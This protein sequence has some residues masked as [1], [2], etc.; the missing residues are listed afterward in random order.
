[1]ACGPPSRG[2]RAVVAEPRPPVRRVGPG[3]L[4]LRLDPQERRILAS[5]VAELRGELEDPESAEPAGA[6]ARLYPPAF[7]DDPDAEAAYADLVLADLVET[8]RDRAAVMAATIDAVELDDA[9]AAAWL[10]TLNDLRLVL[11]AS[12]NI[13]DGDEG[14]TRDPED[15][16]GMRVAV[17]SYLG[18]LVAVFV[19]ALADSLPRV[20]DEVA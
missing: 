6:L 20:P 1:M 15:P 7:P 4:L 3:R 14:T 8:R 5:L 18:W 9:E 13:E 2:P 19:D 16:D 10:G 11:G 12:L 17:F